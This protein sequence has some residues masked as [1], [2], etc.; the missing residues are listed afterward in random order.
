MDYN[1]NDINCYEALDI[2]MEE[3][4]NQMQDLQ[5]GIR[6]WLASKWRSGKEAIAGMFTVVKNLYKKYI[7]AVVARLLQML[8]DAAS[9]GIESL[10]NFLGVDISANVSFGNMK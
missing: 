6:D 9:K 8:S 4:W 1:P 2:I 3:E 10:F 5:E 7:Q